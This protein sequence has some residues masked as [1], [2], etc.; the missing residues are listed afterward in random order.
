LNRERRCC[1]PIFPHISQKS[2]LVLAEENCGLNRASR[3]PWP[4]KERQAMPNQPWPDRIWLEHRA[5]TLTRAYRDVL[6]TLRTYRGRSGMIHPSHETLAERAKCSVST[7]QW[8]LRQ[9]QRLGLVSW[10][11]RRVRAGWRWLRTS[12]CY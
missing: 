12:N 7:V 3:E 10:T 6:L 1:N 2:K 9:A 4:T 11:E 5:G 8:A